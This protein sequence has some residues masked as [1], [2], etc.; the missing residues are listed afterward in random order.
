MR[1]QRR[2]AAILAA[3]V[4]GYSRMMGADEIGT[5]LALKAHKR[6]LVDPQVT[7]HQGRIFK[8]TG[9]GILAEFASVVGAVAAAVT[10]Q[11]GMIMRNELLPE[12][13]RIMFRMGINMGDV[14]VD[15][16]DI[17]G[18]GVNLASRLETLSEPG[19]IC[20]AS[21]VHDQVHGKLAVSF[22]DLGKRTVKNIA[23]DIR[24]FGLGA[25]EIAALSADIRHP[26][27][28]ILG[29]TEASAPPAELTQQIRYCRAPDG[30]E[31]AW[32]M[33]GSGSPLIKA[34]TWMTHLEKDLESPIWR[35]LWRDL[36]KNHGLVRYDARGI[37]LSDW[38]VEDISF[39]AFVR[40]LETVIEATGIERF[41]LLGISQ[42]CAVSIAY[43][44][45]YPER[46]SHLVLYGGFAQGYD[47]VPSTPTARERRAAMLTLMRLGWNKDNP[48]YRQLF[49][50]QFV[51]DATKEQSDW[52]NELERISM[53]PEN[54]ARFMEAIN[55]FDVIDLMPKVKT[56]TLVLHCS[57][58]MLVPFEGGRRM[59]AA[60][61]G[62]RLV[63]LESRNHLILAHEPAYGHFISE[64][65]AFLRT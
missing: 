40:D 60:I 58:D 50:S 10:I 51:P 4:A 1:E 6:E 39:A 15:G 16:D 27:A 20:I 3:D 56:P 22:N 31:L 11:R 7:A 25:T 29:A 43:A 48:A 35:H 17:I 33:I 64:I 23:R 53:S 34:G 59:A 21:C 13:R 63:K 55:Q 44:A 65:E 12:D 42:G 36:A 38:I 18:D 19:G 32:S 47:R 41:A 57:G 54:A 9:D 46:V 30:A 52:F 2:L 45:M 26:T 37:G 62:A 24:V 14:L 8:T 61:P 28:L 49:T 5:L